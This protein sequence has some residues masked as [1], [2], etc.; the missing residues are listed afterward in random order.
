MLLAG[1]VKAGGTGGVLPSLQAE[2]GKQEPERTGVAMSMYY[3]GGDIG[4]AVGPLI[5]GVSLD[6]VGTDGLF[7]TMLPFVAMYGIVFV[8]LTVR[9][10]REKAR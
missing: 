2:C 3:L 9:M 1:F 10:R 5:G 8:Y 6:M 4:Y 7:W